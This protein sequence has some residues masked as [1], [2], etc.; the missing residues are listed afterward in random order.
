M[1]MIIYIFFF[2]VSNDFISVMISFSKFKSILYSHSLYMYLVS[3]RSP[4][5]AQ[6]MHRWFLRYH[7]DF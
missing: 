7:M 4:N 3:L 2:S 5:I 6:R 1:F